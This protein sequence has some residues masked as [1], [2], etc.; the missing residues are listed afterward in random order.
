MSSHPS[1]PQI[2]VIDDEEA[3]LKL[4]QV[5][6]AR[7][8]YRVTCASSGSE[9]MGLIGQTAFDCVLTDAAMPEMSGYEFVAAARS[10]PRHLQLPILMLTRKRH[11]QDVKKA[12]EAGATDYILKPIDEDLLLEKVEQALRR[13][14]KRALHEHIFQNAAATQGEITF[15]CKVVS[16]GETTL[17]LRLPVRLEGRAPFELRSRVFSDIGVAQPRL[18]LEHCERLPDV[19]EGDTSPIDPTQPWQARL[20]FADAPE[21]DLV[22]I[23]AWLQ[24]QAG[25]RAQS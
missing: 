1:A 14:G 25:A 9:G 16:L 5:M 4:L 24:K 23:R 2:L 12:V 22:K 19:A 18:R 7:A 8:G 3:I 20:S 11:R 13:Q 15:D 21:P 10:D 6:L 17:T